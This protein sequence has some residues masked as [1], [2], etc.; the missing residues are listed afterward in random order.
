MSRD[1]AAEKADISVSYYGQIERGERWP[2]LEVIV[3]IAD[4]LSVSPSLFLEFG[5]AETDPRLLRK[6]LSLLLDGKDAKQLQR[7][8]RLL[9]ALLAG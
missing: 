5:S 6:K 4:A 9:T 7:V 3:R 1:T 8:L 2:A